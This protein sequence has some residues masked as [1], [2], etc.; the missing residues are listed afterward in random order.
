MRNISTD[1]AANP[2][3]AL[4]HSK[5]LAE[6][7]TSWFSER[8]IDGKY[9]SVTFSGNVLGSRGSVLHAFTS[10]IEVG[11]RVT[12]TDPGVTRFF[13]TIPEA[14]QLVIQAGAIG[15][16][17]EALVLDMGEPVKIVDIAR[18]MIA[19]SGNTV[20][21]VFTGL[22]PG[23]KLHEN[24]LGDGELGERP[25]H[26]D[27]LATFSVPALDPNHIESQTW[28]QAAAGLIAA[29]TSGWVRE[30]C[31][32]TM[33][34][35]FL[36]APDVG[37]LESK[38]VAEAIASGW[39]AP[40]GPDLN[41]FESEVAERVGVEHAVALSSGTAG[42]HLGLLALGVRP[43]DVVLTSTMTFAATGNAITYVGAGLTFVDSC[44]VTGNIDVA[45]LAD[46]ASEVR[47]RRR[48]IG[49]LVPVDLLGKCADMDGPPTRRKPRGA[50]SRGLR[51][52]HGR[53]VRRPRRRIVRRRVGAVVQRQQ[54]HDH[55]GR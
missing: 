6:Q 49:A 14:C 47:A 51:R 41:A 50:A 43:G 54:D 39:V 10:Q 9:L 46:A 15:R 8:S 28:A 30:L 18:R 21:I 35:I 36:S 32:G 16:P 40:A 38:Y 13:M 12:V 37:E 23:E 31:D 20:E 5:R 26:P 55:I 42:L 7:L 11:G 22:R 33:S 2:I 44:R 1:K 29:R 53:I 52:S 45:L 34:R 4:G 25:L 24:L 19:M 48:H 3:S 17:G 27:D